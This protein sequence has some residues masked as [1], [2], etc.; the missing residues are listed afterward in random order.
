[1]DIEYSDCIMTARRRNSAS[2]LS[3]IPQRTD[4]E[5]EMGLCQIFAV[6]TLTIR[7]YR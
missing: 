1:M 5:V 2:L 7:G 6:D 4:S 3:Q